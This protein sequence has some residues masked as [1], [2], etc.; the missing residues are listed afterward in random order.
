VFAVVVA[1][2]AAIFG[3]GSP[4][5]TPSAEA[6]QPL[7]PDGNGFVDRSTTGTTEIQ[8]GWY[9][10]SDAE[11]C[12][13]N[14]HD[15][16]E[17]SLV[18]TPDLAAQNFPPTVVAD[19]DLGMCVVGVAAQII[20]GPDG[21]P[22]YS[23]IWGFT[24]AIDFATGQPY[25]A[26]AHDVTGVGFDIDSEPPPRAG[27]RVLLPTAAAP[28]AAWW[29]GGAMKSPVHAGHNEFRWASVG[30]PTYLQSPP[31]FD[32]TQLLGIGFQA[33]SDEEGA[34]TFSFCISNLSVLRN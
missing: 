25:D 7:I 33:V 30:G 8:G 4:G 24:I 6:D 18:T 19:I 27:I 13:L 10:F 16:D 3:C 22:D 32:P 11:D 12:Q 20:A 31:P 29:R 5:E 26:P 17:C 28:D 21:E 14:G 9:A 1:G 23:N 15:T 34:K 2:A